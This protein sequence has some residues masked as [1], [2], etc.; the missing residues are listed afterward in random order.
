[1]NA[2]GKWRKG[3]R[4]RPPASAPRRRSLRAH[5]RLPGCAP[6]QVDRHDHHR[7]DREGGGQRDIAG[8]ALW[9]QDRLANEQAGVADGAGM[10]KSPSVSEKVKIEPATT[11]GNA[12]GRMTCE[13]SW[14]A[15]RPGRRMLR[16]AR[17]A[18]VPAPPRR[19]DH[20]GKPDVEEGQE[21][22]DSRDRAATV[23]RYREAE[24]AVEQALSPSRAK[25][26]VR[27][28]S[29]AKISFQA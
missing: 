13:T 4:R 26:Q 18:P 10:M 25:N 12:S 1:M 16:S 14:P 21:H 11:P 17:A 8:S 9:T 27:M 6:H 15:A 28:P 24:H 29:L 5:R 23:R 7:D 19:Q 3:A 22:A 20:V 2:S